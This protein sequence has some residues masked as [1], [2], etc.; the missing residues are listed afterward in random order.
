MGERRVPPALLASVALA[1][2]GGCTDTSCGAY[3]FEGVPAGEQCGPLGSF[4]ELFI[5]EGVVKLYLEPYRTLGD[6]ESPYF[7]SLPYWYFDFWLDDLV[8]GATLGADRVT[9]SCSYF[10]LIGSGQ[11]LF[12]YPATDAT[13][14]VLSESA[15]TPTG[16]RSYRFSWTMDCAIGPSSGTDVIELSLFS[17][18]YEGSGY[19]LPTPPSEDGASSP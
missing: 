17:Q 11:G 16:G 12:T 9:A 1:A 4:G 7:N 14:T 3:E 8:V 10:P 19:P 13:L 2:A 5:D 18:G 15:R 6:T